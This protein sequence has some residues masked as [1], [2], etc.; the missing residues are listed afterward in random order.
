MKVRLPIMVQDQSIAQQKGMRVTEPCTLD[1]ERFFLDGPVTERLAVL[2]FDAATGALAPGTKYDA[3]NST[4]QVSPDEVESPDFLRTNAFAT[5]LKTIHMFEE[6]DTLGRPLRWAFNGP[7]LLVVPVAGEWANAFYERE[8]RCLQF[9]YFNS[10]E[11]RRIYTSLSHDIVSHE[12]GHAILDG[13][14]PDLYH[15]ITPQSLALHEG[16][17]DLVALVMAFRSGTLRKAVLDQT[18]GSIANIT[19]FSSVAEEFGAAQGKPGALRQFVNEKTLD[20]NDTENLVDV[21]EPHELCQV[22]TGALYAV[23]V[24]IHEA[25]KERFARDHDITPFS[26]SGK[27]LFVGAESFKRIIFRAL[28]F[29]PPGEISFA[30][31]ARAIIA[32]DQSTHPD[33][34]QGRE[35]LRTE[36]VRRC[37][38]P[39]MDALEV[40]EPFDHPALDEIDLQTLVDSDWAAY[41]FAN[42]NRELLRIPPDIPFGVRPRLDTSK[43]YYYYGGVKKPI[44]ELIFKVSWDEVEPNPQGSW[45]PDKR[46][47]TVG[48]ML[49]VDWETKQVKARLTCQ[50]DEQ[51]AERDRMLEKL[52]EKGLLVPAGLATTRDGKPLRCAIKTETSGD[53][54]R[55]RGTARTLHIA[56][57]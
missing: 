57:A 37:M 34:P 27:A 40:E 2:D 9:F 10:K 30:D 1:G 24:K 55:V 11:G 47:I 49:A 33:T 14:A 12:T 45:F 50:W 19:A 35:W 7:Q 29:L 21:A 56:E 17:A 15:A 36:F 22:L 52:D 5:V 38:A 20:P 39:S 51:R 54:M 41:D 43:T 42:R 32:S 8:A 6:D 16:I 48:T 23:M 26:A 18:D 53:L 13:I 4:Y 25:L 46:Q 28:D 3:A 44:R 31:Y